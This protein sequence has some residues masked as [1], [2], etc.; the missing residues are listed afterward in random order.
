MDSEAFLLAEADIYTSYSWSEKNA[1]QYPHWRQLEARRLAKESALRE[2]AAA[3]AFLKQRGEWPL[4]TAEEAEELRLAVGGPEECTTFGPA[5]I[6]RRAADEERR[7]REPLFS[8]WLSDYEAMKAKIDKHDVLANLVTHCHNKL[9]EVSNTMT[10]IHGI[11]CAPA[12]A[13]GAGVTALP[14]WRPLWEIHEDFFPVLVINCADPAYVCYLD[15]I[16]GFNAQIG[17]AFGTGD[18]FL[19]LKPFFMEGYSAEL[20]AAI[21]KAM[22]AASGTN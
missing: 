18:L 10:S 17:L 5:A 20:D 22:E 15:H 11:L 12:V 9:V 13:P 1:E 8:M 2:G 14:K 19:S 3:I 6:E 4:P 16:D 21:Q 7:K